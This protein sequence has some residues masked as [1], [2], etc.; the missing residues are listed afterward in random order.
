[1]APWR[2]EKP[3]D[4][5]LVR[6]DV[7]L[8]PDVS[9][10]A[11]SFGGS[12]VSL[13]PGGTRLAFVSGTPTRLFIRQL[14]QPMATEL[15]G[16]QG[17]SGPFFS[18]D[19]QW[20]GFVAANKL[21]KISVN[22]GPVV[23]V[24]DI[25]GVFAGAAWSED[26]SL[27]GTFGSRGL[28]RIPAAGPASTITDF[29][30]KEHNFVAPQILPGGKA[31]LFMVFTS[32]NVDEN[33]I[34][35]LTLADGRRKVVVHGGQSPVYVPTWGKTGHVIYTNKSNLFAVPFDPEKLET[36]GTAV[37]V[38]DDVGYESMTKEGQFRISPAPAGHGTLVYRRSGAE[39][40]GL[41]ILEWAGPT[42]SAGRGQDVQREA[43]RM[44]P[45]VY[46]FPSIS[47]DGTRVAMSLAGDIWV[48]DLHREALTRLTFGKGF[49]TSPLWSP[50]GKYLVFSALSGIFQVRADGSG[51]PQ[52]LVAMKGT[53]FPASFTPDGKRLAYYD[54]TVTRQIGSVPLEEEG[55]H[56][57]AGAPEAFIENSFAHSAP[58]F[59]PDGQWLAYQ[60]NESGRNEIYVRSFP[61]TQEGKGGK[62][63]VSN[64]GGM[65]PQWSQA[66]HE[67]MY[68]SGSQILVASYTVK[69]SAFV[70][71][72]PRVW[73]A[74]L[75]TFFD[76]GLMPMWKLASDGKRVLEV[77]PVEDTGTPKGEHEV[78]FLENFFDE[79]RR[80]APAGK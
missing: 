76:G 67:L 42:G 36:K 7:D 14:D 32:M 27:L 3:Q 6:L 28:M 61:L 33:T 60:S 41:R 38:L 35:V 37:P 64:D 53:R 45:A 21:N 80:K 23:F 49:Y 57:K 70:A 58:A 16:T 75:R 65:W 29:G 56:L 34:E 26:G 73:M 11:A 13:S 74:R 72:T 20:L 54:V 18:A 71:D 1:L 59:S 79:L 63:Q 31:L 66:G 68:Q 4:R 30:G 8:G 19:G 55:G 25:Q 15:P 39:T 47:P 24:S 44:K 10:P 48:Y 5:S 52:I 40:S 78:T 77:A 43:L 2:S 12:A 50:D 69:G 22:G 46:G 62:W 17:A 9:L 51:Q